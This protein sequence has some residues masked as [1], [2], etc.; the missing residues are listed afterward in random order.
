[1]VTI[2]TSDSITV[3]HKVTESCD[4]KPVWRRPGRWS[5]RPGTRWLRA[6]GSAAPSGRRSW[7][8]RYLTERKFEKLSSDSIFSS[9]YSLLQNCFFAA[10][11]W[12][13][14]F[15]WQRMPTRGRNRGRKF[16][17]WPGILCDITKRW[18]VKKKKANQPFV[19]TSRRNRTV[20]AK[21]FEWDTEC[22]TACWDNEPL[23][24]GT[25]VY[26]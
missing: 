10:S 3:A 8:T 11:Y 22:N 23:Y 20:F 5:L 21:V 25:L 16:C 14:C 1:M 18:M 24:G 13:W 2:W 26:C 12:C 4:I 6:E 17:L 9:V 7:G 15:V 19:N